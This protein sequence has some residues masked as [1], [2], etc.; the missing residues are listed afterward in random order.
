MR[1]T[2]N[3]SKAKTASR[4]SRAKKAVSLLKEAFDEDV[5]VSNELNEK[6][7]NKGIENPPSK[8]TVNLDEG[9]LYPAGEFNQ[10]KSEPHET[11]KES[12]EGTVENDAAE[13]YDK[14]VDGTIGEV[15]ENVG[16]L[17]D[18]DFEALIEA[19]KSGKDRKTL[20]E[21]LEKQ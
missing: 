3:I 18:P 14:I 6:I 4:Q 10:E 17:D 15:K 11:D 5:K 19:E 16:E 12:A 9:M 1:R 20:K 7:W 13:D 2:I 21:W 8:V